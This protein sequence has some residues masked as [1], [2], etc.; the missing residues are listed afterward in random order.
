MLTGPDATVRGGRP[1]LTQDAGLTF[2]EVMSGP[3][4]FAQRAFA[5]DAAD[6]RREHRLVMRATLTIPSVTAFVQDPEHT[7]KLDAWVSL[8]STGTNIPAVSGWFKLF[9]PSADPGLKL[10]IYRMTLQHGAGTYTLHGEKHVRRGSV[11]RAW[12]DTT[13]LRC[14]LHA[15]V[16]ETGPVCGEGI[17]RISVA[18]FTKQLASFRPVQRTASRA[19]AA[20]L[21]RFFR[22]FAREL[23]DSYVWARGLDSRVQRNREG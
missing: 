15:G 14:R 13:T 22:F 19:R 20:A 3:F 9:T 7:G 21:A 8:D 4:S 12:P 16:D 18:E 6:G 23:I 17:L 5:T 10:M 1:V 11:L 2:R